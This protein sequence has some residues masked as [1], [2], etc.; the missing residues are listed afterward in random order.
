MRKRLLFTAIFFNYIGYYVYLML[1]FYVGIGSLSMNFSIAL[2]LLILVCLVLLF[3]QSTRL[4]AKLP[5]HLFICFSLIYLSRIVIDALKGLPYYIETSQLIF[6]YL[7]FDMI[8]FLLLSNIQFKLSDFETMRKAIL[9]SG[10]IFSI[11]GVVFFSSYLGT[12]GRLTS[13]TANTEMLSPLALSYC[14]SLA[15]GIAV[16]YWMENKISN[17]VKFYLLPIL[18]LSAIPFFLGSS[19]GSLIALVMPFLVIFFAKKNM[20]S[21]VRML[22]LVAT[23]LVGL[24]YLSEQMGSSLIDRLTST[25]SDIQEGNDSATRTI[26]W[27]NAFNQFINNPILGDRLK[28]DGFNIYPHN[29]FFE[30]LQC[31]GF[32]GF[33]PFFLLTIIVFKKAIKIISHIP[34]YS[35]V[36]ILFMQC[37]IQNMFSGGIFSASWLM[38]SMALVVAFDRM[39]VANEYRK[40]LQTKERYIKIENIYKNNP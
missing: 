23:V 34:A 18:V 36:A 10:F 22:V 37:L 19:R 3:M 1:L 26:M 17:S 13:E 20:L 9:H 24:L 29:I 15:I 31:T 33:I 6:Y 39:K 40:N 32:L 7:S 21:N 12:V 8:P 25:T 38:M 11:L 2:R 16:S 35:W 14:S 28:L 30:I 5:T 27:Q 4:N